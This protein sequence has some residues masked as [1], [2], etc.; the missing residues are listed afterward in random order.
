MR[1]TAHFFR[2]FKGSKFHASLFQ[3]FKFSMFKPLRRKGT[4]LFEL[5]KCIYKKIASG[6]LPKAILY[7]E[8]SDYFAAVITKLT[9]MVL[10]AASM[11]S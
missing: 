9:L 1:H 3:C 6:F 11:L 2:S 4:N 10:T 5:S 7:I 8:Q